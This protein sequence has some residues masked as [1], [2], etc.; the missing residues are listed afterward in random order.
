MDEEIWAPIKGYEELYEVSNKGNVRVVDH[1]ISYV[2]QGR[3]VKRNCKGRMM[4]PW[5]HKGK[6]PYWAVDLSKNGVSTSYLVHRLVAEAFLPNPN[7]CP[8]VNHI[9]CDCTNNSVDNLEW[10][11]QGANVQWGYVCGNRDQAKQH[12]IDVIGTRV[13]CVELDQEFA[14][15][16]EA[17][18]ILGVSND[19]IKNSIKRKGRFTENSMLTKYTV[20]RPEDKD[21]YLQYLEYENSVKRPLFSKHRNVFELRTRKIYTHVN[22]LFEDYNIPTQTR[23][24][25]FL[26]RFNGYLPRYDCYL[27]DIG[28]QNNYSMD[29]V[30]INELMRTMKCNFVRSWAKDVIQCIT[31]GKIYRCS[32]QV[33]EDYALL[34][35]YLNDRI[36]EADGWVPK[37]NLQFRRVDPS[38]LSDDECLSI[39]DGLIDVFKSVADANT[40]TANHLPPC[41]NL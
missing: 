39:V 32:S 5:S 7:N 41:K 3:I 22:Q 6:F 1:V 37:L 35:G 34:P 27:I 40:R 12:Q 38:K 20:V 11:T 25:E 15:M 23:S 21:D 30:A 36:R 31:T 4:H 26:N 9:D 16:S 17:C 29:A 19:F 8:V 28:Y 18:R 10:C 14:S 2:C 33:S 13:Y 24:I